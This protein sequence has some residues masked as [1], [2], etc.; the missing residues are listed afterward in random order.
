[1]AC[2]VSFLPMKYLGLLLGAPLR[3]NQYWMVLL[4]KWNVVG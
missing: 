2:R 1:M 4:R 3:K